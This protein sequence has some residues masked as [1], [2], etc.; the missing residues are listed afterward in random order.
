MRKMMLVPLDYH[1]VSKHVIQLAKERS[2]RTGAFMRF[3]H[4]AK[5]EFQDRG[6]V[7]ESIDR[8]FNKWIQDQGI[9]P[10]DYEFVTSFGKP[11]LVISDMARLTEAELILMAAH[12]HTMVGRL[13]LGSNTDFV[14]HHATC[15]VYVHKNATHS[16][17]RII[18][19]PIDYSDVSGAL[20]CQADALAQDLGAELHFVH[21]ADYPE[22]PKHAYALA[23]GLYQAGDENVFDH[24][25][26]KE[27][28]GI[29]EGHLQKLEHFI[30]S[31]HLKSPAHATIEFGRPYEK[32]L[33]LQE[34]KNAMMIA[35]VPHSHN[36]MHHLFIGSNTDYLVHHVACDVYVHR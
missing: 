19:V 7:R 14:L 33:K 3:L 35:I 18:V 21:V 28:A 9:V 25:D 29:K 16:L 17:E 13:F 26:E 20:A 24:M 27:A 34:R 4:V 11:A 10:E 5:E 22:Y 36:V 15:P 6:D 31:N 32:I 8:N 23:T 1:D 2:Q 12:D 30:E